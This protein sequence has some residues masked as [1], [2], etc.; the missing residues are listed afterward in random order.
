MG[1]L[2]KTFDDVVRFETIMWAA[3]DNR[4]QSEADVTLAHLNLMLVIDATP[5]CRV[6]D[7]ADSLAI[8]VGGASQAVD[9]LEKAGRCVR[10]PHPNDRRS[11]IVELTADGMTALL[12]AEP[13]FD[14]ELQR[15]FAEPLSA[16]ELEGFAAAASVLRQSIGGSSVI[17]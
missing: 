11:S 10:R 6:L 17:S 2:R 1:D 3:L 12:H 8:T 14:A 16:S 5:D 15:I 13:T 7:I 4:L 9:R